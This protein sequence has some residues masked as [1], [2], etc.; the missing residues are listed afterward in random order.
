[1]NMQKH[2]YAFNKEYSLSLEKFIVLNKRISHIS[3]V[4]IQEQRNNRCQ[5]QKLKKTMYIKKGKNN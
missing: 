3:S 4:K 2:M 5:L 1:M